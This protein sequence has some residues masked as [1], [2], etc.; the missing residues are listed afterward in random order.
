M[1]KNTP[2]IFLDTSV[3]IA[4]IFSSTGG[5]RELFHLANNDSITLYVGDIVLKEADTVLLR[6]KPA[7]RKILAKVLSSPNIKITE[8]PSEEAQK[9]ASR[10][11]DYAP[12]AQVLAEAIQAN[13]DWFVSHDRQHFLDKP[14]LAELNFQIG[15][16]GDALAWIRTAFKRNSFFSPN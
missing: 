13:P 15:S 8:P 6:K 14:H 3:I 1:L 9:I 12:D 11:M 2:K 10:L 16:P 5:A 4:A 7:L